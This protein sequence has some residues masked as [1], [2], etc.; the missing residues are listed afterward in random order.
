MFK[1]VSEK[2]WITHSTFYSVRQALESRSGKDDS[3]VLLG[4]YHHLANLSPSLIRLTPS[5]WAVYK[6][7]AL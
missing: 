1:E 3:Q 5:L 6:D 2:P 7:E 4:E